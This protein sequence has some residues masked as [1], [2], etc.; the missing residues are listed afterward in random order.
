MT[1]SLLDRIIAVSDFGVF[2]ALDSG[3]STLN[4]QRLNIRSCAGN[5]SGFLLTGTIVIL[6]S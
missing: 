5:A 6:R 4:Q 3:V 1:A 2:I